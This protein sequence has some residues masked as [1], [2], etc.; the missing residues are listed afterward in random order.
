[1]SNRLRCNNRASWKDVNDWVKIRLTHSSGN[2]K[3]VM[4]ELGKTTRQKSGK[5]CV[6][7]FSTVA[8]REITHHFC[9][10]LV[11]VVFILIFYFISLL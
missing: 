5:I 4:E 3:L 9:S 2:W 1:M 7:N 6:L 8:F 11:L 10:V